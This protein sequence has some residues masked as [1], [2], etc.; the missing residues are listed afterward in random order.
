MT[1]R[2]IFLVGMLAGLVEAEVLRC[3]SHDEH[4][5]DWGRRAQLSA[6]AG[7]TLADA[8]P[9]LLETAHF[10]IFYQTTGP[11]AVAGA[12]VDLDGNGHPDNVDSTGAIAERVWRLGI[13]TLGYLK[14]IP[15]DTTLAYQAV[16]PSG[17]FPI[18]VI[19]IPTVVPDWG[20]KRYMGYA[21]PP[22]TENGRRQQ[23]VIENDFVDTKDRM[24]IQVKVDP[25]NTNGVDSL[26]IDYSKDPLRGWKVAIAHEFYHNLQHRYDARYLYGFHEMSAVWFATRCYP[27]VK[28]HWQYYPGY[29]KNISISAFNTDDMGPYEN[30]PF[31]TAMTTALGDGILKDL[32]SVRLKTFTG[33]ENFWLRDAF[34][35]LKVDATL[36][37]K[38]YVGGVLQTV[39]NFP[40]ILNEQG[41]V[42]V[43][44]TIENRPLIRVT[45]EF[46]AAQTHGVGIYKLHKDQLNDGWNLAFYP[47]PTYSSAAFLR[48]PSGDV[49]RVH[50]GKDTVVVGKR[51][52]DTAWY[53]A[54]M[55]VPYN[56]SAYCVDIDIS[57]SP[58]TPVQRR[59]IGLR[60]TPQYRVDLYGRPVRAGS[61]GIIL[62]GSP[63]T[64][65][66]RAVKMGE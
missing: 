25:I 20:G 27:E 23:L 7:R 16:V 3:P 22:N 66:T 51:I 6:V 50:E 62:E 37:T 45:G 57:Q 54:S 63:S 4:A 46:S 43:K 56:K 2:L 52:E 30:F 19:D 42:K 33:D 41:R 61:R 40:S 34:D 39:L 38:A 65:W 26:L 32:W 60:P 15:Y 49:I 13:D 11:H 44:A 12:G 28:H 64:G 35:T 58:I 1:S 36:F 14:P 31:V 48:A 18:E 24:A 17:K 29:V 21:T 53:T 5:P 8:A 10:A 47:T 59:S 55:N 9:R